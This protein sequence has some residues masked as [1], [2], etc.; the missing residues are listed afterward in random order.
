[1]RVVGNRQEDPLE[2]ALEH[3]ELALA[4]VDLEAVVAGQARD[5]VGEQAGAVHRDP[6][7]HPTDLQAARGP[8][9]RGDPLAQPQL[10]AAVL[11]RRRQR[12][13]VGDRVGHRLARHVER[14][15]RVALHFDA[16]GR[17]VGGERRDLRALGVVARA[18]RGAAADH[19]DAERL[20]HR[21]AQ[22]RRAQDQLGLELPRAGVE[23][24]VQDP[25]VRAARP[26]GE[27]VLGLEQHRGGAPASERQRDR[28]PDDAAPDHRG[29]VHVVSAVAR[30]RTGGPR[31][32]AR[33]SPGTLRRPRGATA[34]RA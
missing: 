6:A 17:G 8:A 14:A 18:Q 10:G 33:R 21:V 7:P 15:V 30:A 4:R 13:R 2:R 1:M 11:R 32:P 28:A 3:E 31:R 12:A 25:R 34:R 20:E 9:D 16:V 26:A 27:L 22:L 19:R 5:L 23:A 29:V 24:G